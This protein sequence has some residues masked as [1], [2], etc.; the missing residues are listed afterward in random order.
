MTE[1]FTNSQ[2]ALDRA[3]DLSSETPMQVVE[4]ANGKFRVEKL[5][6]ETIKDKEKLFA[7]FSC[8]KMARIDKYESGLVTFRFSPNEAVM[9]SEREIPEIVSQYV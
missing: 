1:T 4:D 3:A 7:V 9:F 2:P 6:F 8:G 5:N